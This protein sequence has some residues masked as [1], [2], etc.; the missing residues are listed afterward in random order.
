VGNVVGSNI[1]NVFFV[2]GISATI[3]LLP[4]LAKSNLDIGVVILSGLLLFLSMFTG[5][6]R[7]LDRWEGIV[8]LFLYG[9]YIPYLIING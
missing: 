2:L 6:K 8:L 7:L 1:F 9:G 4:F 5:Q 3:K